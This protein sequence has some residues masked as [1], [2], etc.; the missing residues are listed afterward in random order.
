MPARSNR[1]STTSQGR[2]AHAPAA[3]RNPRLDRGSPHVAVRLAP[4][5]TCLRRP[6]SGHRHSALWPNPDARP[7]PPR[8]PGRPGQSGRP[9]RRSRRPTGS[10][11]RRGLRPEDRC[12]QDGGNCSD[13]EGSQQLAKTHLDRGQSCSAASAVME[14]RCRPDLKGVVA[15]PREAS[16]RPHHTTAHGNR[17][18]RLFARAKAKRRRSPAVRVRLHSRPHGPRTPRAPPQAPTINLHRNAPDACARVECPGRKL[19]KG[20]NRVVRTAPAVSMSLHLKQG[21]AGTSAHASSLSA[22][23]HFAN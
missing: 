20:K 22:C 7:E 14:Q 19:R 13:A 21:H 18:D 12:G 10:S 11:W 2:L 15:A 4:K 17:G 8:S 23:P 3:A 16:A 1:C 9:E 6:A 5:A